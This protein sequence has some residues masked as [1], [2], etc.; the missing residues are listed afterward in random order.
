[1]PV[2][3]GWVGLSWFQFAHLAFLSLWKWVWTPSKKQLNNLQFEKPCGWLRGW[4]MKWKKW[5]F[6]LSHR[7]KKNRFRVNRWHLGQ[8]QPLHFLGRDF[9]VL[10]TL[11]LLFFPLIWHPNEKNLTPKQGKTNSDQLFSTYKYSS[12][13]QPFV[14]N[15]PFVSK[16]I[17]S[18][19]SKTSRL[20]SV[21]HLFDSFCHKKPSNRSVFFVV[22]VCFISLF[23]SFFF[24]IL[25]FFFFFFFSDGVW[26]VEN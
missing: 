18:S 16:K 3:L 15:S 6:K 26:S 7:K 9:S 12:P 17:L 25:A 10:P 19:P 13:P 20:S 24:S 2:I 5:L 1:M 23:F 14:S 21:L 11:P 22:V 4:K 8:N